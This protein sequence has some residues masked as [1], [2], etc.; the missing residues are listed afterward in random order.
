MSKKKILVAGASGL[1]GFAAMREYAERDD[2][3]VI[4]ISR[5][6]PFKTYGAQFISADLQDAASCAEL[7]GSLTGITHVV[8]AALFEK[9]GLVPGWLEQEQIQTNARM[10]RNLLD[11][12]A[13]ASENSLQHVSLLQGTKA[14]GVHVEPFPVP[15]RENRSERHDLDNFYW[16]HENY[17]REKQKGASWHWTIFRPQII[18]GFSLGSA[19]NLIPAL[20]VYAAVLREQGKPL[21]YPGGVVDLFEAVDADLL[22]RA[23][24]WA[25][26][27]DAANNEIFNVTNGDLFT[28]KNVWPALADMLGMEPGPEEPRCLGET[29]PDEAGTWDKIR[30][31]HDLVAPPLQEYIGE[32]FHYADFCLAYG[33]KAGDTAPALVSTI[34]LRQAGFHEVIDTEAMLRKWFRVFED[35]RL[36]P[37]P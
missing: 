9:P 20:G 18:F 22:A 10:L 32:S 35:E 17:L 11:P 23:I 8:Y 26:G 19:M 4:A 16:E 1:V 37:R 7:F 3:E 6:K 13:K 36:L 21:I 12:L 25:G 29:M 33:A 15:A 28:W 27:H 2:C 31:K 5:R 30:R 34:K 24:V 14:Y